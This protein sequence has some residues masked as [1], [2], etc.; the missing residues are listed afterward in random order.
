MNVG[1]GLRSYFSTH[2]LAAAEDA[3]QQA[4]HIES[5]LVA[6]YARRFSLEHRGHIL[7]SI[8]LSV[9]FIEAAINEVLQDAFDEHRTAKLDKVDR[10]V[11]VRW[12]ALWEAMDQGDTGRVLNRYQAALVMAD[13]EPFDQGEE[14]FQSVKLLIRLRN[15]LIHYK[16]ETVFAD[17]PEKL[18]DALRAHVAKNPLS[19]NQAEVDGWLSNNCAEWAIAAAKDFVGEFAAR[20]GARPNYQLTLESL[21]SDNP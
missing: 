9:A 11:Q 13:C 21:R 5:R 17:S 2:F 1:V 14:P 19:T 18:A 7:T 20:T 12:A 6:E 4:A 8:I 10:E 16:P 3:A 15:H